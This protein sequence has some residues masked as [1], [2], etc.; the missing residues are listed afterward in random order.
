[1][2][3]SL[4]AALV[5]AVAAVA[6]G[7][8]IVRRRGLRDNGSPW[9]L[10]IEHGRGTTEVVLKIGAADNPDARRAFATELAALDLAERHELAAPRVLAADP[11]GA[12]TGMLALLETAVPG[13]SRIPMEASAERLRAFGAAAAPLHAIRTVPC[14]ELP[15]RTR[16]NPYGDFAAE[17]RQPGAATTPLLATAD[18][19]IRELPVPNGETRFVHADLWHGNLIWNGDAVVGLVDWETAGVGHYGVDVGGLR[20]DTALLFGPS[21]AN[22][23]LEGWRQT[24]GTDASELPYWD[25]V[26]ALN[27][28]TDMALFLPGLHEH[29]R[30]DLDAVTL[31]ERRDAFLRAALDRVIHWLAGARVCQ[32][33][34]SWVRECCRGGPMTRSH[35][36]PTT[37]TCA[38]WSSGSHPARPSPTW[39]A[40]PA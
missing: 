38:S 18:E 29:G 16:P 35:H 15:S 24:M 8:R 4:D 6:P 32:R 1:M 21:A 11:E 2:T 3:D 23:A 31:N 5:W 10:R 40:A 12:A 13:Q 20:L 39:A 34:P 9:W 30:V 28:P 22:Q 26:A 17:R 25:A 27:L 37:R 19:R 36:G 33:E 7:G 14:G